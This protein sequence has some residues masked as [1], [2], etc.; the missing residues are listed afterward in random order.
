MN[1]Q[2]T[3]FA[4]AVCGMVQ[5]IGK[6]FQNPN[7]DW[8]SVFF[9]DTPQGIVIVEPRWN[10]DREKDSIAYKVLPDLIREHRAERV[11]FVS[12]AWMRM[13]PRELARNDAYTRIPH[14]Q[15]ADRIEVVIVNAMDAHVQIGRSAIIHRDG[16]HPPTLGAFEQKDAHVQIGRMVDPLVAA[17]KQNAGEVCD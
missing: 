17:L 8:V 10:N 13:I 5:D 7:D 6:T 1:D 4:D 9:L 2:L 12:S 14:S 15:A 11:V 3:Q 16:I